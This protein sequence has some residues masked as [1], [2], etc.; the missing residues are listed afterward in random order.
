MTWVDMAKGL[1]IILV[2]MMYSAYNTGEYTK[3]VGVLHYAIGFATPF[4]MPEFFLI[5]GLFLS[6]VISRPWRRYADRRV[7][8]YFYFYALWSIVMI[9]L[10]VGIYGREP[11]AMLRE[12]AISTFHP[13]GV[14]WFIYMLAVFGFVAKLL[15]EVKVPHIV[16]ISLGAALQLIDFN[17]P[18]YI[19]TQFADYFVFFYIGYAT[20]PLI[21]RLVEWAQRHV[22][23]SILGLLGWALTNG[24][25]VFSRGFSVEP[26]AAHMGS[27]V[28]P[29]VHLGLAITGALAVCTLGALLVRVPYMDWLRWLGEH[30]LV[31][32]VAFT[33]PMSIFRALALKSGLITDTSML[34]SAV[35][36]F[37]VSSPIL[38]YLICR[39]MDL[40]MFLFERPDWAHIAGS[41]C[42]PTPLERVRYG[43]ATK[44]P[45]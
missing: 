18:S 32:Y 5:S 43:V 33:L 23:I 37:S 21:T 29:L 39:R 22:A 10:K 11:G 25:L 6:Q 2:V 27:A 41:N 8:H 45:G 1:S 24:M 13:Y 14:L 40:G 36:A 17:A 12:M 42:V 35:L 28:S 9:G 15:W 3:D 31:I 7:L 34:S 38:V 30:S 20:A 16:V 26:S 19:L 44:V 4:R